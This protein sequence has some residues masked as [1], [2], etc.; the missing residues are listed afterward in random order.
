MHERLGQISVS[1]TFHFRFDG[2]LP[3]LPIQV[4]P[5]ANA[6][7]CP[8]IRSDANR[9]EKKRVALAGFGTSPACSTAS[10][11]KRASGS[12]PGWSQ[13]ANADV[14]PPPSDQIDVTGR[15]KPVPAFK[16]AKCLLNRCAEPP[17]LD[18]ADLRDD[19]SRVE[20]DPIRAAGEQDFQVKLHQLR[21]V[22]YFWCRSCED[23]AIAK[24]LGC[25]WPSRRRPHRW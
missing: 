17:P 12:S 9:I 13:R 7:C 5:P 19:L 23:A 24:M 2:T 14:S 18:R 21:N 20:G 4:L 3:E 1:R 8:R 10:T 11:R 15:S 22:A 16:P 25:A 6:A